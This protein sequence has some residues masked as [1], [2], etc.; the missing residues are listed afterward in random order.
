ML[1]DSFKTV[2]IDLQLSKYIDFRPHE[3]SLAMYLTKRESLDVEQ[4]YRECKVSKTFMPA[5]YQ[6]NQILLQASFNGM[7][8]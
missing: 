8:F 6:G 1:F 2:P 4:M 7:L 5:T 3:K